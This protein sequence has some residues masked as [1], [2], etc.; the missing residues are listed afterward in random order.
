M[1][2]GSGTHLE[3][4]MVLDKVAHCKRAC[5]QRKGDWHPL[6]DDLV[7]EDG[8]AALGGAVAVERG[9][10]HDVVQ[11]PEH[12]GR[13]GRA[14]GGAGEHA[15]AQLPLPEALQELLQQRQLPLH[16]L[17]DGHCQHRSASAASLAPRARSKGC[18]CN[19]KRPGVHHWVAPLGPIHV[20]KHLQQGFCAGRP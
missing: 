14:A 15:A 20:R 7:I 13:R 3:M 10:P 5:T 12:L 16:M 17:R 4:V 6:G 18:R 8:D 2:K 19:Y 1:G 11:P 9:E